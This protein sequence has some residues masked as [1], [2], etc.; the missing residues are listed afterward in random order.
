MGISTPNEEKAPEDGEIEDGAAGIAKWMY[1][2]KD[3]HF[4]LIP[5]SHAK[6]AGKFKGMQITKI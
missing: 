1:F 5:N 4:W 2:D 3:N 6:I